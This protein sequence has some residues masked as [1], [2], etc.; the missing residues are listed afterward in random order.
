MALA[1]VPC[2]IQRVH[3]RV[4]GSRPPCSVDSAAAGA[5]CSQA[6]RTLLPVLSL[7]RPLHC[8]ATGT[9]LLSYHIEHYKSCPNSLIEVCT[10]LPASL[11]SL[12]ITLKEPAPRSSQSSEM[13]SRRGPIS[14]PSAGQGIVAQA[15]GMHALG[16]RQDQGT[17]RT[18][19][20][21]LQ[22]AVAS[23]GRHRAGLLCIEIGVPFGAPGF[24]AGS[25]ALAT[26]HARC[27]S[28]T[29]DGVGE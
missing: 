24:L 3:A 11:T 19:G 13:V 6:R 14:A 12:K 9:K 16:H 5:I 7:P 21:V 17:S 29:V 8:L 1:V 27:Y 25:A 4:A 2:I 28:L 10:R 15:Q 20:E 23:D 22:T 26:H 18:Q